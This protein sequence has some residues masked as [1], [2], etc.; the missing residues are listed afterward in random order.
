MK[1]TT[2]VHTMQ[3]TVTAP[4]T[5][6]MARLGEAAD[7]GGGVLATLVSVEGSAYRRP[8]AKMVLPAEGEAVGHLTAGCLEPEIRSVADDVRASGQRRIETYD[9]SAAAEEGWGLGIGCNGV[10]TVLYEPISSAERTVVEAYNDGRDIGIA[11]VVD[12][13]SAGADGRAYYDPE[14][15]QLRSTAAFPTDL[16][17]Q[18]REAAA[19]L[20]ETGGAGLFEFDGASVCI[21]GIVAPD[22]L[23]VIGTGRDMQPVVSLGERAGFRVTVIGYRG[24]NATPE[25]FPAAET[26]R[27]TSPADVTGTFG[28]D[29]DTYV[30][31]ATH[32]FVDDRLTVEQLLGTE[33]PYIGLMGPQKRFEEMLDAFEREERSVPPAQ[34]ERLYTPVGLDVGSDTPYQI[35]LSIV[36]EVLAV[37]N[38]R[39]PGHL[40][41]R[42]APIH[43]RV[44]L[45]A[46][47]D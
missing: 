12:P 1:V 10:I 4:E 45:S 41:D 25:R 11:R 43:D 32:N 35:A 8:G 14:N 16:R 46:G 3:N 27:S 17:E 31:V 38:D 28:F 30:V 24:A 7:A 39:Q 9:L 2:V 29:A 33:V 42:G 22:D 36:G 37:S 40:R 6:V 15:G 5:A 23:V 19:E 47:P 44:E 34:L 13:G 20:L 21:D 18:V 26:V